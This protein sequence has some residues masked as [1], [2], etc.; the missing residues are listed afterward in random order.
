[1]QVK[2]TNGL[3]GASK[4]GK[5][6]RIQG[7]GGTFSIDFGSAS[8]DVAKTSRPQATGSI[9][10]LLSLQEVE[11]F[12]D[13]RQQAIDD[14]NKMLDLLDSIKTDLLAGQ[15]TS[16]RLVRLEGALSRYQISN[17]DPKLTEILKAVDLRARVELAKYRQNKG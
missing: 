16:D 12:A 6:G 9:D 10:T 5:R 1:M 4:A 13:Q 7:D 17:V 2:A 11:P 3:S 14:S 8:E 15:L